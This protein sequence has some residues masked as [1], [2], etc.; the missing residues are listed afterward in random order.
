MTGR[1]ETAAL[2]SQLGAGLTAGSLVLG[3]VRRVRCVVAAGRKTVDALGGA[4]ERTVAALDPYL[5]QLRLE[6][7]A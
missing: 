7:H 6:H 2:A 3:P 5:M 4:L 1:T